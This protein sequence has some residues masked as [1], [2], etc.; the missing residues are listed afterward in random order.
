M[1]TQ[2]RGHRK[3]YAEI[4]PHPRN[5]ASRPREGT[6][7]RPPLAESDGDVR[8]LPRDTKGYCE[9]KVWRRRVDAGDPV[10]GVAPYQWHQSVSGT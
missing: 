3:N 8:S 6:F 1:E 7:P 9:R 10:A 4:R 5:R 2:S